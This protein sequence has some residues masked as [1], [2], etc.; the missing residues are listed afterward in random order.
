MPDTDSVMISVILLREVILFLRLTETW[1]RS[2]F[3]SSLW[4]ARRSP[5]LVTKAFCFT[6][7]E[8]SSSFILSVTV[9]RISQSFSEL[10]DF[11]I[12]SYRMFHI[13]RVSSR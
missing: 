10:R 3:S 13:M 2:A 5:W 4:A 9:E 7:K 8:F 1:G 11:L 12:R 6:W